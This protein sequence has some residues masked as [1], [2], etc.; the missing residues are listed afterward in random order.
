MHK[1]AVDLGVSIKLA[2]KVTSY[3]VHRPS[4]TLAKGSIVHADLVIAADGVNSS[5]R[6]ILLGGK[7]S[8]LQRTGFSAYRAVVDI[9]RI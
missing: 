5:T 2:S 6:K 4:I 1:L 8:L 9:E 7:E 3:D